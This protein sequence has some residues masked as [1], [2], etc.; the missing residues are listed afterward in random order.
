MKL[1]EGLPEFPKIGLG[2]DLSL[3]QF[4]YQCFEWIVELHQGL[5]IVEKRVLGGRDTIEA[6]DFNHMGNQHDVDVLSANNV[7]ELLVQ[8]VE[9]GDFVLQGQVHQNILLIT[10]VE[11]LKFFARVLV[12]VHVMFDIRPSY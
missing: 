5:R 10:L 3:N 9:K 6:Y 4:R 8:T 11:V 12:I 1:L 7:H 2:L